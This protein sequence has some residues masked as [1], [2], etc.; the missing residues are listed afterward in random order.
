MMRMDLMGVRVEIPANTPVVMLREHDGQQRLLPILIGTAEASAIHSALEGVVPPRPLTHDLTINLLAELGAS[1]EWVV[2]TEVRDHTYYAEL[3]L[4]RDG[5]PLV[6]SSRPSDAIALAVRA[7]AEIFAAEDL[8]DEVGVSPTVAID[9]NDEEELV[10][11]FREFLDEI[12][13]EDF[14]A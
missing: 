9:A 11:E 7:D 4:Q 8:L 14:S 13:P 5:E 10:D 6:V 1:L 12:N 3:H 2:I